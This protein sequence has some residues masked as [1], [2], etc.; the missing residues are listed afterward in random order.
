MR[1]ADGLEMLEIEMKLAGRTMMIH[2]VIVHD[3]DS[4]TLID[5]GMLGNAEDIRTYAEEAGIS[6]R[7]LRQLILTHQDIDHIGGLPS[8]LEEEGAKLPFEV[9]AHEADR[10]VIDGEAPLLKFPADRL[11]AELGA[12]LGEV[13]EQY[14]RV[15]SRPAKPNVTRLMADGETLPI[16]GGL[17]VIH[18]PGHTPGHVSLYHQASKTLIAGD[19]LVIHEG[20]LLPSSP[21]S[22]VDMEQALRSAD[23]LKDL[24]IEAVI[25]Y[26][27]GL[28]QGPGISF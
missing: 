20:K 25:C 24:D 19:A 13:S 9:Y 3:E 27:G 14:K 17:T 8:F 23:K 7:P 1:V 21:Y 11:E 18:T 12:R 28:L 4:W 15:F 5:A 2:P 16:G 6:D 22:T 26:H 10:A